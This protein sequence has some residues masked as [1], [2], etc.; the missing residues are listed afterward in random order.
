M[1][2][3]NSTTKVAENVIMKNACDFYFFIYK[4]IYHCRSE[5]LKKHNSTV[6]I[7]NKII[8]RC[9]ILLSLDGDYL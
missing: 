7:S 4:N 2:E 3:Q 1:I 6:K 8:S 5:E 9:H